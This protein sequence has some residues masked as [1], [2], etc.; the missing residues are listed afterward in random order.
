MAFAQALKS[1][2]FVGYLSMRGSTFIYGL[3]PARRANDDEAVSR[4]V[5]YVELNV[6]HGPSGPCA[7]LLLRTVPHLSLLVKSLKGKKN[8]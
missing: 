4:L 3:A 8:G 2:S 5:G 7:P 1:F 6:V